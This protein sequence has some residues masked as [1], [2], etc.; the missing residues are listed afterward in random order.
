MRQAD[1]YV[2]AQ[3]AGIL[4]EEDR[5]HYYFEYDADY[6]GA[7]VSLSMPIMQ[8]K[9]EYTQFPFFFD[10]LLPEGMM[11]TMLLKQGKLDSKDYLGQLIMVGGDLV[12][13]VTVREHR[14]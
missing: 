12:G 11:L 4:T 1:I 9:Y 5:A 3:F 2:D 6:Q 14:S 13:N 10:G 8:R 7:P